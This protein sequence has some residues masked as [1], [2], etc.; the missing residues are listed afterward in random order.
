[1]TTPDS[2]EIRISTIGYGRQPIERI[3]ALLEQHS[4]DLLVDVRS[5]PYSRARPEFRKKE[6]AESMRDNSVEYLFL[7]DRLGGKPTGG[8]DYA[9]I[10]TS[11]PFQSGIVEVIRLAQ[12]HRLCLLCAEENPA[13]CHRFH[14]ITPELTRRD[15]SVLHILP[16]GE[17]IPDTDIRKT[18][19]N[20]Q[21]DLL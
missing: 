1:M 3:V 8:T 15:V 4:V 14:L 7:G 2:D 16:S 19:N 18:L 12:T 9:T 11:E 5:V 21:I 6:L 17:A 13:R 20:N 10:R